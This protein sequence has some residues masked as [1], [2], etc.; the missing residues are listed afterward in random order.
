MHNREKREEKRERNY[1]KPNIYKT[2]LFSYYIDIMSFS[3]MNPDIYFI[4]FSL[5][6]VNLFLIRDLVIRL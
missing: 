5:N 4:T 3:T 2:D 1:S 6:S